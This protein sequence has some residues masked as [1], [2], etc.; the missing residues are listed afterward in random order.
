MLRFSR[1]LVTGGAGFIGSHIVDQ[2]IEQDVHV[3]VL[4]DLSS[5]KPSILDRLPVGKFSFV[6]GDIND[7]ELVRKIVRDIEVIFLEA[8][9]V[10][11]PRSLKEPGLT[12][13][14]N[15]KGTL[16]LLNN[17]ANS[18]V[19]RFIFASSA[20]VYGNC[21]DLPVKVNSVTEPIS[22]YGKSKL[23]AEKLCLELNEEMGLGTTILRYFNVYGPRSVTSEESGVINKFTEK[24]LKMEAPIIIGDGE[25]TRDFV[26]VKDVAKANIAAASVR[27]SKCEIYNV[28]T[29]K[30]ITIKDLAAL[31][32]RIL[33]G[34]NVTIPL[35]YAPRQS[36]DIVHSFA[37]ISATKYGLAFEPQ[38]PLEDGLTEYLKTL[39]PSLP[40]EW[41]G[42]VS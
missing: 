12:N 17:A 15:V 36:A 28:A 8:A 35:I 26:S 24:L 41:R 20:A 3:T 42:G 1:A 39:V 30:P 31:M 10:S 25:Q 29:G 16:N 7:Q 11:V 4:D 14:V 38:Y 34:P 37:D 5:G 32:G 6:K 27:N 2:L 23:S 33:F 19:E 22:P 9:I 40:I 18:N 13:Q 21:Q